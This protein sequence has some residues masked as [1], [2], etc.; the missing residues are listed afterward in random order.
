MFDSRHM[1]NLQNLQISMNIRKLDSENP[2]K[3]CHRKKKK[4]LLLN[5]HSAL[6]HI[7]GNFTSLINTVQLF[8]GETSL[9]FLLRY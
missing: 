8:V 2:C 9:I 1:F 6:V 7:G 3:I 5:E 4:G